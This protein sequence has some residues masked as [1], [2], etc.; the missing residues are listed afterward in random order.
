MNKKRIKP[1]YN[2]Q[3]AIEY[4]ERLFDDWIGD[5]DWWGGTDTWDI[6]VFTE[7]DL[8]GWKTGYWVVN[9]FGLEQDEDGELH[10]RTE[11]ELDYFEFQ[12]TGGTE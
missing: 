10:T 9:V 2:I 6:N 8:E 1:N 3:K 4:L 7:L 5:E 12:L 11:T